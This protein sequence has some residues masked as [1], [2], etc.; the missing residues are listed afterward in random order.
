MWHAL[1]ARSLLVPTCGNVV[2]K[3]AATAVYDHI[4]ILHQKVHEE[5]HHFDMVEWEYRCQFHWEH[6]MGANLQIDIQVVCLME[7]VPHYDVPQCRKL[8]IAT[9]GTKA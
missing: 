2:G 9:N 5:L 6:H 7:F 8:R 4:V 1:G 3:L